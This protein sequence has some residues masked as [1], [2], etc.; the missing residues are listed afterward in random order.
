MITR[1]EQFT[2][3]EILQMWD[4][5]KYWKQGIESENPVLDHAAGT[6]LLALMGAVIRDAGV[7]YGFALVD[8]YASACSIMAEQLIED[9]CE[10]YADVYRI[11]NEHGYDEVKLEVTYETYDVPPRNTFGG[12]QYEVQTKVPTVYAFHNRY[13]WIM[14]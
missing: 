13:G 4:E 6:G 11:M 7:T 3:D 1:I 8:F 10:F 2:K 9:T 12:G 14:M 5:A